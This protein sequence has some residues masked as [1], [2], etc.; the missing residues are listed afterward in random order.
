MQGRI[1]DRL[2]QRVGGY[3]Q[4]EA[5]YRGSAGVDLKYREG[6]PGRAAGIE[7][8]GKAHTASRMSTG[9]ERGRRRPSW[10]RAVI[11]VNIVLNVSAGPVETSPGPRPPAD[12]TRRA[13]AG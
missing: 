6:G 11:V 10:Q 9:R 12:P 1:V 8:V 4:T 2:N 13:R 7:V 5:V 3:E